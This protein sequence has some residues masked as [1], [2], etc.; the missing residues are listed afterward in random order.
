MAPFGHYTHYYVASNLVR[1]LF[2]NPGTMARL[3][4]CWVEG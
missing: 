1:N 3:T 4:C 2:L